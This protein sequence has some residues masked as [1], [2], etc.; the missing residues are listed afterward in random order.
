MYSFAQNGEDVVL[1]RVFAHIPQGRYID[2]G[3]GHPAIRSISYHFYLR[4]WRGILVEPHPELF[5]LIQNQRPDDWVF[6]VALGADTG[7]VQFHCAEPWGYSSTDAH[8]VAGRNISRTIAVPQRSLMA[9][10]VSAGWAPSQAIHFLI[11]DVEGSELPA[12][13]G[14]DLNRVR[15]WVIVIE[16]IHAV[17]R[18]E[19]R[20]WRRILD[21]HN[22]THVLFD[23]VSDYYLARERRYLSEKVYPPCSTDSYEAYVPRIDRQFHVDQAGEPLDLIPFANALPTTTRELRD[24]CRTLMTSGILPSWLTGVEMSQ[25]EALRAA[26]LALQ[27]IAVRLEQK[28]DP[29]FDFHL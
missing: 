16:S 29:T 23:G 1:D 27:L 19:Y 22:Y 10:L 5:L 21:E 25:T 28:S 17:T 12:L 3:A 6:A 24:L 4:G 8:L 9:L 7:N 2:A 14:I 15:P 11:L 20:P 26:G 18:A 13:A